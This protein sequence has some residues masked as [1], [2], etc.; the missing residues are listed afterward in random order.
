MNNF[1][2][3]SL[4]ISSAICFIPLGAKY[5]LRKLGLNKANA[6]LMKYH[7][8]ASAGFF[9]LGTAHMAAEL[10]SKKGSA[11][12]NYSGFT[13]LALTTWLIADCHMAKDPQKKM[14]RH[15]W[16]SLG[17]AALLAVHILP[18]E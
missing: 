1:I 5:P 10:A 15:R 18:R 4:G 3:K 14:E 11:F 16:Y 2:K 12:K 17:L 6:F 7:E 8:H 13:T 9:L